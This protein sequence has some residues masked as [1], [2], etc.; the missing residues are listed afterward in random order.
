MKILFFDSLNKYWHNKLSG[1]QKEFPDTAFIEVD[2][3]IQRIQLLK[4]A[5]AVVCGRITEEQ[6]ENAQSL[7]AIFVPFTGIDSFP[8]EYIHRKNILISNTHAN[9]KYVAEHAVTLALSVMGRVVEFHED[10]FSG[11][12]NLFQLTQSNY[13]TTIQGKT[14][15]VIGYGEIGKHIARML[16]GFDC[17]IVAFKKHIEPE[18]PY[19]DVI[20][21]NLINAVSRGNIIFVCLPLTKNTRN[22]ISKDIL[23]KMNG[24]FLVNIG[25]GALVD[26]EGLYIS[27]K[28]GILA[29]AG[30]DVWYNY[31]GRKNPEPVL[32]SNYPIHE[33]RNVVMSPHKSGL[34]RESIDG[35]TDDTTNSIRTFLKTGVPGNV[36]KDLY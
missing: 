18:L 36:I 25:R 33:L 21:D 6:L 19:A 29:G 13:W 15:S 7:K 10:L 22:I 2:D 28:D 23:M 27:L 16:K 32:P 9:S 24:K 11:K 20:T 1:L 17:K 14:C 8:V 4:D 26:E 3:P 5:D 30:L 35:M 31:P 12:W 34:T